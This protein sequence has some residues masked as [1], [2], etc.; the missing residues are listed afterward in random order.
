M[1]SGQHLQLLQLLLLEFGLGRRAGRCNGGWVFDV[2][3]TYYVFVSAAGSVQ[4]S[5]QGMGEEYERS[6]QCLWGWFVLL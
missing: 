6:R 5:Q 1:F 2:G 4:A 3:A